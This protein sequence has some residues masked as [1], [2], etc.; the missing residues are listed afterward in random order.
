MN[1]KQIIGII[2]VMFSLIGFYLV[3]TGFFDWKPLE[4]LF[5]IAILSFMIILPISVFADTEMDTDPFSAGSQ[6]DAKPLDEAEQEIEDLTGLW[7]ICIVFVASLVIARV[8][9]QVI[10]KRRAKANS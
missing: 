3:G 5:F 1:D 4:R 7:K 2:A 9:F 10:K 6:F 8:I